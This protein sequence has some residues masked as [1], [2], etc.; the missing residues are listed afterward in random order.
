MTTLSDILLSVAEYVLPIQ[1]GVVT[2]GDTVTPF[3]TITDATFKQSP[4]QFTNGVLFFLTGTHAGKF[5]VITD[6]NST[7][8]VFT[9][10]DVGASIVA[11]V[12]Y[13]AFALKAGANLYDL[14][15]S[16]NQSLRE[17]AGHI[18]YK[19]ATLLTITDEDEY[20]IPSGVSNI[21]KVEIARDTAA[22]YNY[23][24]FTHWD[25]EDGLLKIPYQH[26]LSDAYSADHKVQI[27]YMKKHATL[28]TYEDAIDPQINTNWLKF[29]SAINLIHTMANRG[30]GF[31]EFR[32]I[33]DEAQQKVVTMRPTSGPPIVRLKAA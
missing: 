25:E 23:E 22:P 33:L 10:A 14:I 3:V 15:A 29:Q 21:I 24:P 19:D 17:Q 16:V 8:G 26:M 12:Q 6:Y 4:G 27:T 28:D 2:T 31:E 20:T 11:G 30:I 1:R 32:V 5:V 13:A 7:T 18:R 9:F